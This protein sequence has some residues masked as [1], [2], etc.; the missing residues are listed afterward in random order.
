MLQN[1]QNKNNKVSKYKQSNSTKHLFAG[2]AKRIK[3]NEKNENVR[4]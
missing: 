3:L 2:K 1:I 4:K